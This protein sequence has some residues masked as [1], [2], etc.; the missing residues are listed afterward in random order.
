M[1]SYVLD[2]CGTDLHAWRLRQQPNVDAKEIGEFHHG[3]VIGALEDAAHPGWLKL[4]GKPGWVK[5]SYE[6]HPVW[7]VAPSQD[8]GPPEVDP[9]ATMSSAKCK[10]KTCSKSNSSG[11]SNSSG[12]QSPTLT[13]A[14]AC[15]APIFPFLGPGYRL[16][17]DEGS[18]WF[19]GAS[20]RIAED[21]VTIEKKAARP[22]WADMGDTTDE[23]EEQK[24]DF[25]DS[26]AGKP[27][28]KHSVADQQHQQGLRKP[29]RKQRNQDLLQRRK[30]AQFC[31]YLLQQGACPFGDKCWFAHSE[32]E[33]QAGMGV[34]E[35]TLVG[36]AVAGIVSDVDSA[37]V[38][39]S[40]KTTLA[41]D[42]EEVEVQ[43]SAPNENTIRNPHRHARNK[44]L[45]Q[46]KNKTQL[47]KYMA[48][49]GACRFGDS[50]WFAHSESELQEA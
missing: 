47:C 20:T 37:I 19:T 24:Q 49:S 41:I 2:L 6:D 46:K 35:D 16:A 17:D 44:D 45:L 30:K 25:E 28:G 8:S 34:H 31:R 5:A 3:D 12:D 9:D 11:S 38:K 18:A 4:S 32:G 33:V 29:K 39:V 26:S 27:L 36:T 15:P 42:P 13:A 22:R 1:E 21:D 40:A 50:C 10:E 14:A 48:D 7:K 43:N 23:E